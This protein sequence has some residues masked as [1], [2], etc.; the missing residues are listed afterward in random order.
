M[1]NSLNAMPDEW[2][3]DFGDRVEGPFSLS[4]LQALAS[5]GSLRASDRVSR[6]ARIWLPADR[7]AGLSFGQAQLSTPNDFSRSAVTSA[8]TLPSIPDYEL[9][10]ALGAGGCGVVYKA[11][12]LKLNRIVALKTLGA[13]TPNGAARFEKEAQALATLHHPNVVQ[14]F[15]LGRL[16]DGRVF[17]AMELLEG[18]DLSQHIRTHGPLDERTA[19][20]L[21]RQTAA[22]LAHAFAHGIIHRDVKPANLFLV[23]APMG[24]GFP[25]GVPMVKVTDFGLALVRSPD[26]LADERLT[27]AG[28][29]LG[30]PVYMAPEQFSTSDIDHRAD[31]YALGVTLFHALAGKSPFAGATI[32]DVMSA[33]KETTPRL[34]GN[35]SS[36]TAD[37]VAAMMSRRPEDRPASYEDVIARIDGLPFLSG[38]W[39]VRGSAMEADPT[40]TLAIRPVPPRVRS[41]R[42]WRVGIGLALLLVLAVVI[43]TWPAKKP[44]SQDVPPVKYAS[45]GRNEVLFDGR[46]ILGWNPSGGRAWTLE[47]DDES[48]AVLEGRGRVVRRFHPYANYRIVI[49]LDLYQASAVEMLAATKG[50]E[51]FAMRITRGE[52]AIFGK[53]VG[54]PGPFEPLTPAVP[55]PTAEEREGLRPYLEVRIECK[56]TTVTVSFNGRGVGS[57][58]TQ[59]CHVPPEVILI[60]EG[61][62][63]RIDS[64]VVD[65]LAVVP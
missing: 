11:R 29:V 33:K 47:R 36:A 40:P 35:V 61:G 43:I 55:F 49:G 12:Q 2:Y 19:W 50:E 39:T 20:H 1:N 34:E 7:V 28:V 30:T 14:V 45:T 16:A 57:L 59:G 4:A 64:A 63:V 24:L 25:P 44:A 38:R 15:D 31:I 23:P 53:H 5:A 13:S 51:W 56:A 37:L 60:A 26:A 9:L 52:G 18:E 46:T 8:F 62:P 41:R 21:A 32:W 17:F 48:Q 27:A 58:P 3:I 22:G 54:E 42:S 65:E 6:D 10:E